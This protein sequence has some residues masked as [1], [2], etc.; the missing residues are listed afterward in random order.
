MGLMK[1]IQNRKSMISWAKAYL[2]P[3]VSMAAK[4]AGTGIKQPEVAALR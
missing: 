3:I 4:E 1:Y 2:A